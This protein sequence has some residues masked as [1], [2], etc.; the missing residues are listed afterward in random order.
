M[1]VVT[2]TGPSRR[3][4]KK[5]AVRSRIVAAGIDLAAHGS[6]AVGCENLGEAPLQVRGR[7]HVVEGSCS[8]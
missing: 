3:D 6:L 2:K 4:R 8:E 1:T 7:R 5:E